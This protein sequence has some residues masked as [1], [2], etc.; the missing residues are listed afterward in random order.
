MV[1][2]TVHVIDL[3][4]NA[5]INVIQLNK[6]NKARQYA[7]LNELTAY[8]LPDNININYHINFHDVCVLYCIDSMELNHKYYY[9]NIIQY[10]QLC[11][12]IQSQ[13]KDHIIYNNP[14]HAYCLYKFY[15]DLC[16]RNGIESITQWLLNCCIECNTS[17]TKLLHNKYVSYDSIQ[18]LYTLFKPYL[19]T[20]ITLQILFDRLQHC[21]EQSGLLDI[22]TVELDDYVHIDTVKMFIRTILTNIKQ[23]FD[24]IG[25]SID[26]G[27]NQNIISTNIDQSIEIT[28]KLI[29]LKQKF[30][31]RG[32]IKTD[33]TSNLTSIINSSRANSIPL[34]IERPTLKLYNSRRHSARYMIQQ[35]THHRSTG[36]NN[37]STNDKLSPIN[38]TESTPQELPSQ[39]KLHHRSQST[40]IDTN[41]P[42]IPIRNNSVSATSSYKATKIPLLSTS[43]LSATNT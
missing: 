27:N 21:S 28:N 22:Q 38:Q 1:E 15:N 34:P 11:Y 4:T 26:H 23:T 7:T 18:P 32:S 10:I 40:V 13:Y 35:P 42:F 17:A 12:D 31:K 39:Y 5:L 14:I 37:Q 8:Q 2:L 9:N 30:T 41:K 19:S 3:L 24:L 20:D 29:L 6:A 36:K 16:M 43:L 33:R 25:I